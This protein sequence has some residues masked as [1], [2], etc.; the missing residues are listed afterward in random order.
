MKPLKLKS[1]WFS[2]MRI[3][4]GV[5]VAL[6]LPAYQVANLVAYVPPSRPE[7]ARSQPQRDR[8]ASP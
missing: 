6:A 4:R 5:R 3:I 2:Y 1:A 7:T 8:S